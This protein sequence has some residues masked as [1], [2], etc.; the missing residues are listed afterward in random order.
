MITKIY[1]FCKRKIKENYKY[2]LNFIVL[3]LVFTIELPVTIYIPGG[4]ID[5]SKRVEVDKG[6]KTD[7]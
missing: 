7:G 5:L 6:Y 1:E 4:M 2:L 3:I